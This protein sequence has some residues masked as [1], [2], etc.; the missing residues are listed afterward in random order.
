LTVIPRILHQTWKDA[1][2]PQPFHRLQQSWLTHNRDWEYRFWT[3]E[4][5]RR[6][7]AERYAWFLP[8]YDA[9]VQPIKRVDAV[10]YLWM[11]HFGGVYADLDF[12]C[13]RP[14]DPLLAERQLVLGMEPDEH[15]QPWVTARGLHRIVCNAF[16][17][18][19]PGHPFWD[20]V[21]R[22]L[23]HTRDL[24]P[25]CATGPFFL[26]RAVAEYP[27]PDDLTIVGAAALYPATKAQCWA[28]DCDSAR[29]SLPPEAFAV[30]HFYGTWCGRD[31]VPSPLGPVERNPSSQRSDGDDDDA[32]AG[33]PRI[34]VAT[35]LKN[36]RSHLP[37]YLENLRRL[38]HPHDRISIAFLE[39]DSD[40]GTWQL[41]DAHVAE[42]RGRFRRVHTFKRDFG[43]RPDGPRW[44]AEIQAERRSILAKSRNFLLRALRDEDWVLW[45]DVDVVDYPPD[46]VERLLATQKEIVVPHCIGGDGR[47]FDLNT[48]QLKE[49]AATRDWT[50]FIIDGIVQP[51]RGEGR[52]YLEDLRHHPIVPVDSVGGTML[53]VR[54][55]LHR[56]GLV[57]PTFSYKLHIETEGLAMMARDMGYR[58]WGL[59]NLEIVHS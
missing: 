30:H 46:I 1:S 51:P 5:A 47:T 38:T 13:L 59:P 53:L 45:L 34:L 58:C 26:T 24:D 42:L 31:G 7:V 55:D 49:G 43:F 57:F 52:L 16:I 20:Y 12:E 44:R 39:S 33:P 37:R 8:T 4:A 54:G 40:D 29:L 25:L 10:R 56:E 23:E 22:R 17:A 2:V 48:F 27:R 41:L 35:P 19:A 32:A 3:D 28:V 6:F 15:V 11:H 36:A 21:V 50:P 18:S 9:Y 14:L